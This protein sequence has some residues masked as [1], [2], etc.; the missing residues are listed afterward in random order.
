M[1]NIA[2][3]RVRIAT[4]PAAAMGTAVAA[5]IALAPTAGATETAHESSTGASVSVLGIVAGAG[6]TLGVKPHDLAQSIQLTING[7]TWGD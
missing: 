4:M 6:A 2:Q 7:N 5:L 3:R 1:G